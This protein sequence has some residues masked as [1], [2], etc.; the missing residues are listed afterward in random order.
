MDYKIQ[1]DFQGN[2]S[3]T[4]VHLKGNEWEARTRLTENLQMA[5]MH[6]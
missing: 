3:K 6:N 2:T 1:E 4:I 5:I